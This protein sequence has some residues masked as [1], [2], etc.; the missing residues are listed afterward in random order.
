[1]LQESG[2]WAIPMMLLACL[3]AFSKIGP[4]IFQAG[5]KLLIF[6]PS[7]PACQ[8][9]QPLATMPGLCGPGGQTQGFAH[10]G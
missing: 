2:L 10:A 7:P 9:S 6:L 8:M 5:L 1:M 4:P 3:L